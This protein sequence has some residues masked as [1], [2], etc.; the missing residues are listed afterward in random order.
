MMWVVPRSRR[1]DMRCDTPCIVCASRW[2]R[3][4][5]AFSVRGRT[6]RLVRCLQCGL[7]RVDPMPSDEENRQFHD[8]GEW[9]FD[10]GHER[11]PAF[12]EVL[13]A[14]RR[15]R[16]SGRLLDVGCGSG[17]LVAAA[18]EAGFDAEGIEISREACAVAR[19]RFQLDV[20][21]GTVGDHRFPDKHFDVIVAMEMI[22]YPADP[23]SELCEYRRI[24]APG[25]I[26][27]VTVRAN[28]WSFVFRA[29]DRLCRAVT[30]KAI[31]I[32]TSRLSRT[33]SSWGTFTANYQFTNWSLAAVL[34]RAGWG[35]SELR[36]QRSGWEVTSARD[37]VFW[38][39]RV[40]CNALERGSLGRCSLGPKLLVVAQAMPEDSVRR[41]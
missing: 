13:G 23:V 1:M 15:R 8:V 21:C 39:Y 14:I 25:G 28:R 27:V 2:G 20:A 35:V 19:R 32:G 26:L 10:L 34:R 22:D 38:A 9:T 30:G 37:V 36:N 18:R 3:Y 40:A 7:V 24:M 29:A 31:Q 12:R 16:A 11:A 6:R 4:I 33:L 5:I 17:G 41:I